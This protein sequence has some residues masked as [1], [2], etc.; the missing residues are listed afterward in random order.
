MTPEIPAEVKKEFPKLNWRIIGKL[1]WTVEDW[2]DFYHCIGF[3]LWKINRRHKKQEK[4]VI[5]FQI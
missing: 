1:D 4:P 3:A 2:T 5:D